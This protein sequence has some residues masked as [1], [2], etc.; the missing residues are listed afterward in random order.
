M[1]RDALHNG[2]V[3]RISA[4]NLPRNKRFT[5]LIYHRIG[6]IFNK[7]DNYETALIYYENAYHTELRILSLNF[8]YIKTYK[9]NISRTKN[10]VSLALQD[11]F[12]INVQCAFCRLTKACRQVTISLAVLFSLTLSIIYTEIYVRY[13]SLRI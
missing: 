10:K 3:Y 9:Y 5:S 4:D 1:S 2:G 7:I 11:R 13:Y 8:V 12:L 6:T